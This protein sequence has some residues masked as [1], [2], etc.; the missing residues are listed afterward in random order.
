MS[1]FTAICYLLLSNI[2]HLICLF[3]Q[4]ATWEPCKA[5]FREC[6]EKVFQYLSE[7]WGITEAQ[8]QEVLDQE[9]QSEE[10]EETNAA[11]E[12]NI[13][14]TESWKVNYCKQF[15]ILSNLHQHTN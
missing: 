11:S 2:F 15:N 14:G 13:A 10:G 8:Y 1:T 4:T 12:A 3:L 5:V 9:D 7:K 6:P